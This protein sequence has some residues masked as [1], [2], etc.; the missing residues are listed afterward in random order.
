MRTAKTDD[1]KVAFLQSVPGLS[2]VRH[3]DLASLA[4]LFDELRLNAGDLLIREGRPG[5]EL[6]L[7]VEGEALVSLRDHALATV[8]PG[9]LLGEMALFGR[10]PTSATVSALTPLHVLVAG[11]ES[12]S[13]LLSHP[14]ML[15]RL[16]TTLAHRLRAASSVAQ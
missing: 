14:A 8:G 9:E 7:I 15:R 16:A 3:R 13:A 10:A 11:P 4:L 5:R 1:P 6:F 2:G 12:F